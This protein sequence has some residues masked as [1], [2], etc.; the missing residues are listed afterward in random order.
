M[1]TKD[2]KG[3]RLLADK[4]EYRTQQLFLQLT[5]EMLPKELE[6]ML[7]ARYLKQGTDALEAR[8]KDRPI[9]EDSPEAQ[10][11]NAL[12]KALDAGFEA[13][14]KIQ[15][16]TPRGSREKRAAFTLESARGIEGMIA[17]K[18]TA[19]F[20]DQAHHLAENL[21]TTHGIKMSAREIKSLVLPLMNAEKLS[22]WRPI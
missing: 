15:E 11:T 14:G 4:W 18:D 8:A 17:D 22:C 21:R 3:A 20:H 9:P 6:K 1:K 13:L 16:L 10:E 7:V 12:H 19:P 5:T 2:A